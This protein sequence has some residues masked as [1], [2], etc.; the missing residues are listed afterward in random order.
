MRCRANVLPE[1]RSIIAQADERQRHI[2][3]CHNPHVR[4]EGFGG[5]LVPPAAGFVDPVGVRSGGRARLD[6]QD[7]GV[8]VGG[9]GPVPGGRVRDGSDGVARAEAT[10]GSEGLGELG[11]AG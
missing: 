6:G 5:E 10:G 9:F 4:L 8:V 11:S 3:R 7:G 1:S 2:D